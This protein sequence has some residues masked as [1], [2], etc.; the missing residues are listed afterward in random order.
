MHYSA[1]PWACENPQTGKLKDRPFMQELALPFKDF[2]YR[3]CGAMYR[4]RTRIWN[5]LGEAWQPK[6]VCDR[7]PRCECF[8][9]EVHPAN[10]Q[11]GPSNK[12][13][14]TTRRAPICETCSTT[15][16]PPFVTKSQLSLPKSTLLD[17]LLAMKHPR[18]GLR[19]NAR[20][21]LTYQEFEQKVKNEGQKLGTQTASPSDFREPKG[22]LRA[23]A[24]PKSK[25]WVY[26]H[27]G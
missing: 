15:F 25:V 6:A 17:I 9:K 22:K 21:K 14:L 3:K 13:G 24:R 1:A 12:K 4:K 18:K 11:R 2:T 19:H 7:D 27:V 10:A 16:R 8:A 26:R 23:P 5:S 20:R